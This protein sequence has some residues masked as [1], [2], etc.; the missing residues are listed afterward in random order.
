TI[1]TIERK[2]K[3]GSNSL[4]FTRKKAFYIGIVKTTI[5]PISCRKKGHFTRIKIGRK[6]VWPIS[7]FPNLLKKKGA[8]EELEKDLQKEVN[9]V[10]HNDQ[11]IF[12][13]LYYPH[14]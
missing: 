13:I 12:W 10:N 2:K 6:K 11:C 7:Q 8:I 14:V 1:S 4:V 3:K 9:S 5:C